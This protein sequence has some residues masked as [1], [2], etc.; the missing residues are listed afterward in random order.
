MARAIRA[1]TSERGRDPR[2]YALI[3]FGGSGPIH[4]AELVSET[5]MTRVYVPLLPGLFSAIGLQFADQKYDRVK[6]V[7]TVLTD[8][9]GKGLQEGV[10]AQTQELRAELREKN[11][12]GNTSYEAYVDLRYRQQAT[13][14]TI[15]IPDDMD[16]SSICERLR[17]SFHL[18]QERNFGYRRQEDSVM[19]VNIRV[20]AV[21]IMRVGSARDLLRKSFDG[22][23]GAERARPRSTRPAYFGAAAGE[24]AAQVLGRT[25]L[26]GGPV[27]G[28]AIIEEFDTTIVI[29]PGW[30]AALD[31]FANVVIDRS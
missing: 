16:V 20:R 19:V 5:G 17:E 24:R 8:A 28:P 11:I 7:M 14:L 31:E 25:D 10:R 27:A 29:P 21:V 3:A 30:T 6:S 1:V 23:A 15:R 4:A 26:L 2:E 9:Y 22:L 18:E 12:T 13:E